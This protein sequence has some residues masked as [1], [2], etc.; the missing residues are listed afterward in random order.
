MRRKWIISI[1]AF[2]AIGL[3]EGAEAAPKVGDK[4]T[5]TACPAPGVTAPCL[6][7]KGG[8]GTLYNITGANPKPPLDGTMI[9]LRGTVSDKLSMCAQGTVLALQ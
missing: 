8:D 1:A 7:I 6:M 3:M 5:L 2:T 4:V 9:H